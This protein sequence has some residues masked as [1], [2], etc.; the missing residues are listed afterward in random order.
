MY[1][2]QKAEGQKDITE[3]WANVDVWSGLHPEKFCAVMIIKEFCLA[4]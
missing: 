1:S 4:L 2:Y 3:G